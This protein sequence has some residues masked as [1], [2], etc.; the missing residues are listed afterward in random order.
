MTKPL[1]A[2]VA[3]VVLMSGVV[4]AQ[5]Y[6]PAPPPYPPAPPPPTYPPAPPPDT[7]A[8]PAPVPGSSTKTTVAPTPDGG[9][10]ASTTTKGVDANG[11]EVTK[12]D[13]YKEG[14]EGNSETQTK[15][16]TDP[17]GGTTTRSTTTTAPR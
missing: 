10:R 13:V 12:K 5:V 14:V 1:L 7:V 9:Y 11:N 6:S 4:S 15:T 16:E 17:L 2:G 3:A 8:P